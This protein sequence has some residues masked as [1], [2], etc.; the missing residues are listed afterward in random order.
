MNP[1][2]IGDIK[3]ENLLV[4]DSD[5]FHV[6]LCD[7]GFAAHCNGKSLSGCVGSLAFAAPEVL[8]PDSYYDLKCDVWSVGVIAFL[9][10]SGTQPFEGNT[11]VELERRVRRGK[12][13]TNELRNVSDAAQSFVRRSLSFEPSVRPSASILVKDQWLHTPIDGPALRSV[14]KLQYYLE[15]RQ[16]ERGYDSHRNEGSSIKASANCTDDQRNSEDIIPEYNSEINPRFNSSLTDVFAESSIGMSL[17]DRLAAVRTRSR[18]VA[19]TSR[20]S[21]AAGVS[22]KRSNGLSWRRPIRACAKGKGHRAGRIHPRYYVK[23]YEEKNL[24][25]EILT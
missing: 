14:R 18:R 12:F 5:Q 22:P 19:A 10:L 16:R 25:G 4:R 1:S 7:F 6:V 23:N 20:V 13:K 15:C 9:L 17:T 21:A 3:P 8:C 24:G 11:A 2:Q